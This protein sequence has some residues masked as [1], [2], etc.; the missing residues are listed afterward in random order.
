MPRAT[1]CT[2]MRAYSLRV[3]FDP[4]RLELRGAAVPLLED[5]A[6]DPSFGRWTIQFFRG[7]SGAGALAYRTGKVS[8]QSYPVSWLDT[9]GPSH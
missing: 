2:F 3:P 5:L 4:A 7:P 6:S 1:W 8:A 9:R